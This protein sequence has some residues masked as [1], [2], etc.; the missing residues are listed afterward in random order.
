[1]EVVVYEGVDSWCVDVV[2]A[3]VGGVKELPEG[4]EWFVFC[5]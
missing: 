5:F 2:R 3:V 1:M 4:G